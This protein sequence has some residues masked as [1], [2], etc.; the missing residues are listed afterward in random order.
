MEVFITSIVSYLTG[1]A[2]SNPKLVAVFAI[3]YVIG[4][5]LK[6][7]RSAVE[8]YV[9]E[10]PSASDDATLAKFEQGPIAKVLFFVMD[11]LIRFK[12]Q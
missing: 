7:I 5:V 8:T 9:K 11:L 12:K 4:L 2:T 10:S 6:I 3:L 1:L